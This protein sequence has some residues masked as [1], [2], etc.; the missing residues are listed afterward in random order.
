MQSI[1]EVDEEKKKHFLDL[2]KEITKTCHES[3]IRAETHLG[4]E[5]FRFTNEIEAKAIADREKYYILR[6]EVIEAYFYLYRVTKNPMYQNW[7]WD[8][9]EVIY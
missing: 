8:A 5:A 3:Y 4:P 2:A 6:P 1:N 7:A 9:A